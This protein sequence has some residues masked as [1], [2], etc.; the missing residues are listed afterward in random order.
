MAFYSDDIA[1]GLFHGHTYSANPLAC[2]TALA[3]LELLQSEEIQQSIKAISQWHQQFGEEIKDHPKVGSI[4]QL[5]VI[6]ALDLNVKMERYGNLRNKLFTHFMDQGVFLRPLGST[7]YIL[8]PY[9]TTKDQ[10]ERIYS[11]IRSALELV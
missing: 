8:A 4:R 11:A 9:V 5:G 6:F 7:I 10:M 2:T 3:A 1:K